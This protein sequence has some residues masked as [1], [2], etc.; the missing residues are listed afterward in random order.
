LDVSV[1]TTASAKLRLH[2]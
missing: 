1:I 2:C